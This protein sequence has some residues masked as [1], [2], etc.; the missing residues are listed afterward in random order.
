M[1]KEF[2]SIGDAAAALGVGLRRAYQLARDGRIPSV[3][4]GRSLLI[5]RAAW[6][7]YLSAQTQAALA[8]LEETT[9]HA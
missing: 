7:T 6:E 4:R 1:Q 9:A 8:R 5:P 3:R 2:L